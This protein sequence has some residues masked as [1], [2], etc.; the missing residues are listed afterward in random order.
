M[1]LLDQIGLDYTEQYSTKLTCIRF[2][3]KGWP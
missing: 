3:D 1:I 2:D